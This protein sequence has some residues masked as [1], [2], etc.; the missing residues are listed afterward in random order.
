MLHRII[1]V[2]LRQR[3]FLLM[4]AGISLFIGLW[5]AALLPID[6]VPDITNP[7]V[8]VNTEVPALAPEESEMAVTIPLE[9]ELAGIQDVQEMRSLTK[10]GLSQ[11]TL[12]FRMAWTCIGRGSWWRNGCRRPGDRLPEGLTPTM[13][14]ISTGLGEIYYYTVAYREN[15]PERPADPREALR[16]L[17]EIH[18][19]L[20]KP[21]LRATPGHC[22]DQRHRRLRETT[23]RSAPAGGSQ[24]AGLTFRGPGMVLGRERR[25]RRGRRDSPRDRSADRARGRTREHHRGNRRA[26]DQVRAGVKPLLVGTWRTWRSA[27]ASG[28]ARRRRTG[29]KPCWG[30]R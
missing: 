12:I 19:F 13:A 24:A 25:E 15:A 21:M 14:P 29:R 22:R 5:S 27:R 9:I 3:V 26:A 7:Q 20:I 16:E 23:G 17:R 30:P 1:E 11:V 8:Q 10:F 2:S 28:P 4:V 18:E 6:A